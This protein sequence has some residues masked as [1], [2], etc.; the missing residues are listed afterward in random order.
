MEQKSNVGNNVPAPFAR[1]AEEQRRLARRVVLRDGVPLGRIRCVAGADLTFVSPWRTPTTGL[2]CVALFSY[3]DL[4]WLDAVVLKGRVTFPYVPGFLSYR[5]LPLLLRAFRRVR[6]KVDA[7]LVDAQGIAHPRRCG[8]ASHF[9]VKAG[10]MSVGCAKSHLCGRYREPARRPGAASVL[11]GEGRERLG[12][13]LR[14]GVGKSLLFISPG[15]RV[16]AETSLALAQACLRGHT[17]PEPT[18]VAHNLLV[19]ER[20]KLMAGAE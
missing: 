17:L 1:L 2:A 15:H 20:R 12:Y 4:K 19:E 5:E 13:V 3:P 7:V 10:V 14:P 8:L 6:D 9:G 11:Q 18:R 16:S